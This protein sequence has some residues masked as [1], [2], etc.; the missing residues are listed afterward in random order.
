MRVN[1]DKF[2]ACIKLFIGFYLKACRA[3]VTEPA[4]VEETFQAKQKYFSVY[5]GHIGNRDKAVSLDP[6][7][8]KRLVLFKGEWRIM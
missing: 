7:K 1:G 2:Y 6:H 5:L 4:E 3:Y 8:K